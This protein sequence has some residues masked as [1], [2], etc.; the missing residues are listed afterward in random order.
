MHLDA[1]SHAIEHGRNEDTIRSETLSVFAGWAQGAYG[2][3]SDTD[4]FILCPRTT[5]GTVMLEGNYERISDFFAQLGESP[6]VLVLKA[7]LIYVRKGVPIHLEAFSPP[8]VVTQPLGRRAVYLFDKD[9]I[10]EQRCTLRDVYDPYGHRICAV[11]TTNKSAVFPHDAFS[12]RPPDHTFFKPIAPVSGIAHLYLRMSLFTSAI[13]T[14]TAEEPSRRVSQWLCHP[15]G[16]C[17]PVVPVYI[18]PAVVLIPENRLRRALNFE[19]EIVDSISSLKADGPEWELPI[20]L[21]SFSIE[22]DC[23]HLLEIL[24]ISVT[25]RKFELWEEVMKIFIRFKSVNEIG[26][27]RI[28]AAIKEFSLKKVQPLWV[29]S[30]GVF[31]SAADV[32]AASAPLSHNSQR[33]KMFLP[34]S[35]E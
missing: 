17:S 1:I 30:L 21:E 35:L 5:D 13:R 3:G 32:L 7:T 29:P 28:F 25:R 31:A 18:I 24:D 15:G 9:T 16:S 8:W 11:S 10:F 22:A 27:S 26:T 14:V 6:G 12:S 34:S 33:W 2:S 20:C 23:V 19:K 4:L